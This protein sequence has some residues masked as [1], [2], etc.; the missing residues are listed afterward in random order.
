MNEPLSDSPLG[1]VR[2]EDVIQPFMLHNSIMRGR[3]VRMDNALNSILARHEYPEHAS[4]LLGELLM[5]AGM[6]SVNLPENGILTLQVKGDGIVPFMVADA[7]ANGNIRG[8]ASITKEAMLQFKNET[9]QYSRMTDIL[10]KGYLAMTL[11]AP[12]GE[13]YQGIVPLEGESLSD[14]LTHYFTQSQQLDVMFHIHVSRRIRE[15]RSARW[16]CGGIM[17]ERMPEISHK[18]TQQPTVSNTHSD[19]DYHALLVKTATEEELSDPHLAPSALLYRLF[20]ETGVWVYDTQPL[21][22]V[23]RCSRQKIQ[24]TLDGIAESE[25]RDMADDGVISV[26]CQFCSREEHF[27]VQ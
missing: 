10:G 20:N 16:V 14:A 17:L 8:Y 18:E 2:H 13:P 19:W 25:L 1:L 7:Q 12:S 9:S 26:T 21:Q 22:D 24:A 23:C 27:T 15:D 4:K 11:D 5:L 6:L 3:M